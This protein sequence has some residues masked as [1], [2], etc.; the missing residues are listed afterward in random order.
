MSPITFLI[1]VIFIAII[2]YKNLKSSRASYLYN[3]KPL[4]TDNEI[5]F[6]QRLKEALPEYHILCQVALGALLQPNVKGNNRKYYS[7]RGTFAQKIADFVICD[8]DMSVVTIVELDDRTHSKDKD[9]KRDAMLEEAG[10]D[11]VRWQSRK[12]P[13]IVE[14]RDMIKSFEVTDRIKPTL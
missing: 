8:K 12:K 11:V 10:Y 7:I 14:I 13:S 9:E 4:L 3:S 5:E 1:V 2:F 6:Y